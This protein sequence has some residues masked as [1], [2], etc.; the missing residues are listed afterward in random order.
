ML[1]W[2]LVDNKKSKRER[3]KERERERE[4]ERVCV[5]VCVCVCGMMESVGQHEKSVLERKMWME[6]REE[7]TTE[8]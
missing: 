2:G 5:C 8:K 1:A 3:E 4:R 7:V 6:N